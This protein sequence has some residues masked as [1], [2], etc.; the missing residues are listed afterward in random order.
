MIKLTN[1]A[2][3]KIEDFIEGLQMFAD[4]EDTQLAESVQL[5]VDFYKKYSC[6]QQDWLEQTTVKDS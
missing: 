6:P 1:E 2:L 4:A 3:K 5:L